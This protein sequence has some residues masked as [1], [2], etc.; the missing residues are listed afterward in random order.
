MLGDYSFGLILLCLLFPII[1]I[2]VGLAKLKEETGKVYL[3]L[4]IGI[5][6]FVIICGAIIIH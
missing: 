3:G 4:S 5:I 1:G 6:A 2:F